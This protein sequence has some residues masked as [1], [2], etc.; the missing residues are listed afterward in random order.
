M[1][2]KLSSTFTNALALLLLWALARGASGIESQS[3]ISLGTSV[4]VKFSPVRF[5]RA[6]KSFETIATL[7]NKSKR[8]IFGTLELHIMR[9]TKPKV[10]L[11]NSSGA[12]RDGHSYLLIK[13]PLA[14]LRPK[15][16]I[17][18]KVVRFRNPAKAK[19][20]FSHHVFLRP[21][22]RTLQVREQPEEGVGAGVG[23]LISSQPVGISCGDICSATFPHG[24]RVTLTATPM[25]GSIF[26]GWSGA[27]EAAL[28]FVQMIG[29][30]SATANFAT[31]PDVGAIAV[32]LEPAR[33]RAM[34]VQWRRR[35]TEAWFNSGDVERDVP[36][37]R[38]VVEFKKVDGWVEPGDAFMQ[39]HTDQT[40]TG[41]ETYSPSF[42]ADLVIQGYPG[43]TV[44]H[45]VVVQTLDESSSMLALELVNPPTGMHLVGRILSYDVPANATESVVN[46]T[47]KATSQMSGASHV[48]PGELTIVT[49]KVVA[50]GTVAEGGGEVSGDLGDVRLNIPSGAVTSATRFTVVTT[51]LPEG[52]KRYEVLTEPVDAD[53]QVPL[54]L[55]FNQQTSDSNLQI[56]NNARQ[57][58]GAVQN[59]RLRASLE[60]APGARKPAWTI[61]GEGNAV[62]LDGFSVARNRVPTGTPCNIFR[63]NAGPFGLV[64]I[65]TRCVED[66][67]WRLSSAC[68]VVGELPE[69]NRCLGKKPILLVHG[70]QS[71]AVWPL[72]VDEGELKGDGEYWSEMPQSLDDAGFAVYIFQWRTSER[73]EDGAADLATAIRVIREQT[74]QRVHIVAHSF[75]GLLARTYLQN[76]AVGTPYG[77]EVASLVTIG[78]PHSGIGPEHTVDGVRLP[79]GRV[80]WEAW[81]DPIPKCLQ[82]S[83]YQ[84]G[85]A[86]ED[87]YLFKAGIFSADLRDYLQVDLQESG[88]IP[89]KLS[90]AASPMPVPMLALIGLTWQS[91]KL[92]G[93]PDQDWTTKFDVGDGL[94]SWEGQR[95]HPSYSCDSE[96]CVAKSIVETSAA[97]ALATFPKETIERPLGIPGLRAIT[98]KSGQSIA[99]KWWTVPDEFLKSW[100]I[101]NEVTG[102]K[103]LI[104]NGGYRHTDTFPIGGRV[105]GLKQLEVVESTR[106]D[107]QVLTESLAWVSK[108]N[109]LNPAIRASRRIVDAGTSTMLSWDTGG[110]LPR[111]CRVSGGG[112]GLDPVSE[113]VG[114]IS[115]V[116]LGQTTFSLTC[117]YKNGVSSTKSVR[118]EIVPSGGES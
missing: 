71:F 10:V 100:A 113:A 33:A 86:D 116:V 39:V 37:G 26:K 115:V 1:G 94:I 59:S 99:D 77:D 21:V 9:I 58:L 51:V 109:G 27:C 11:S 20:A 93:A 79:K 76:L 98:V 42:T 61:L 106:A 35:G 92:S 84:A 62:L 49:P 48:F 29:N 114:S 45:E 44:Y 105:G 53:F 30:Q 46:F 118:V 107:Q 110:Y 83:C 55:Y 41:S 70:Y 67:V 17:K 72:F 24:T 90:S 88:E 102:T 85:L 81:F 96:A 18:S 80:E 111:F 60:I 16:S 36:S 5:N 50:Q 95:I 97:P 56:A 74:G 82:L 8:P 43:R 2:M 104:A 65:S 117:D 19:F 4:A 54:Q 89:A 91:L 25:A 13:L 34:S 69:G 101:E 57:Y 31:R 87:T 63:G 66:V 40:E 73:F 23:G 68:G 75:G 112:L 52:S 15:S 103:L 12:A 22:L 38:Q 64:K 28:C 7:T 32:T 6:S 14:G 47:V 108:F 78:T 3:S